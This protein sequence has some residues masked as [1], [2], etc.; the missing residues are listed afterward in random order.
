[1]AKIIPRKQI[2]V[3]GRIIAQKAKAPANRVPSLPISS[4]K[5]FGIK[6][7]YDKTRAEIGIRISR[8]LVMTR[9][10]RKTF[11][12]MTIAVDFVV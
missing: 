6:R 12:D 9:I 2:D 7:K 4:V 1:L 3:K 5:I 8:R 10:Q 11:T